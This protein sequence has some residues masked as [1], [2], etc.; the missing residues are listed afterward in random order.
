MCGVY[1]KPK[2]GPKLLRSGFS[3]KANDPGST[4][5]ITGLP[6]SAL[7]AGNCYGILDYSPVLVAQTESNGQVVLHAPG[8]LDVRH[9]HRDVGL[10]DRIAELNASRARRTGEVVDEV[11]QIAKRVWY[12]GARI[13]RASVE[14]EST[15]GIEWDLVHDRKKRHVDAA[16]DRMPTKGV[17][18]ASCNCHVL[19]ARPC[20]RA[21][22]KPSVSNGKSAPNETFG[23]LKSGL[24][25]VAAVGPNV[26]P[27]FVYENR[28]SFTMLEP[29]VRVQPERKSCDG[30]PCNESNPGRRS[31]C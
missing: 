15:A 14:S 27:M 10:N 11:R 30:P 9:V 7:T 21:P 29:I 18:D 4:A 24:A 5:L 2:R 23:K 6:S 31:R 25:A 16:L 13:S 1:A 26:K 3:W 17:A 8:V 28:S 22:L 19:C 20:G 12:A